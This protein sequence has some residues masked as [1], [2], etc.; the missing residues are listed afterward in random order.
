MWA[1]IT[2]QHMRARQQQMSEKESPAA[3]TA[4]QATHAHFKNEEKLG[5]HD[6]QKGR[7][8]SKA[9]VDLPL[10]ILTSFHNT[11]KM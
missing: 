2:P 4:R 7:Y 9:K 6:K 5:Q 1:G 10:I 3:P 8:E 11:V